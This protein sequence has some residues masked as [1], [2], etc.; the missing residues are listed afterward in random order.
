MLGNPKLRSR[1]LELLPEPEI[2]QG[3][4]LDYFESEDGE[5]EVV[6]MAPEDLDYPV[7]YCVVHEQPYYTVCAV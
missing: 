2:E 6:W 3:P 1:L 7:W 5:H 4:T